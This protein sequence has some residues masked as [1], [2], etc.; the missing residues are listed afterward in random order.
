ML[1]ILELKPCFI[2]FYLFGQTSF[3]PLKGGH[4]NLLLIC[5][6]LPRFFQCF[7]LIGTV[8]TGVT[9]NYK[10]PHIFDF[11]SIL[12][13]G[14]LLLNCI[15]SFLIFYY[16]LTFPF[17]SKVICKKFEDVIQYVE[18]K[19]LITIPIG[20]FQKKFH[21]KIVLFALN[22]AITFSTSVIGS[23]SYYKPIACYFTGALIIYKGMLLLH[24][25]IFI[26][27]MQLLLF[28]LNSKLTSITETRWHRYSVSITFKQMK[29]IHLNLW[30]IS[31]MLNKQ[32][33]WIFV[34]TV[35]DYGTRFTSCAYLLI[36]YTQL[37]Q[38]VHIWAFI[39]M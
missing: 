30:K 31:K 35:I 28:S 24:I 29:W 22:E 18:Q 6:Y 15:S 7:I 4:L 14:I 9:Q 11:N 19:F 36:L 39:R 23:N 20:Y 12:F 33:G 17:S 27:L 8:F 21:L 2:Y 25:I 32:F 34:F 37:V 38:K 3:I 1:R 5:S 26:E 10:W 16:N 13:T